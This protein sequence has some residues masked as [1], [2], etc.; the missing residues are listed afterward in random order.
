VIVDEGTSSVRLVHK[1]LQDFFEKQHGAGQL[2]DDG[3]SEIART[4]I[5]Y[6]GFDRVPQEQEEK[7]SIHCYV[8]D[9]WATMLKK[10]RMLWMH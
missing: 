1:S 4:C 5:T 10:A 8:I 9:H 6:L 7:H 3:H 2:F